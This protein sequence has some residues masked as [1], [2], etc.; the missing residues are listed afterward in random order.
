MSG[1][2]DNILRLYYYSIFIYLGIFYALLFKNYMFI[3]FLNT[4]KVLITPYL[5]LK[6]IQP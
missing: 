4:L 6:S 1:A 2:I 3:E 5:V